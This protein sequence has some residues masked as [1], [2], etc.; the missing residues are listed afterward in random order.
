MAEMIPFK[1]SNEEPDQPDSSST[2]HAAQEPTP[3]RT[4]SAAEIRTYSNE[5][6]SEIIR[7]GLRSANGGQMD[8]VNHEEMLAIGR[9]FGLGPADIEHAFDAIQQTKTEGDQQTV[10]M[11]WFKVHAVTFVAIL[12]GLF[13]INLLD[14]PSFWWAFFPF[15]GWGSIVLLHGV[16]VRYFPSAFLLLVQDTDNPAMDSFG[17]S[18]SESP[19][20]TPVRF[21]IPELHHG[22]AEANGMVQ[23]KKDHLIIECQTRDTV[24]GAIKS[25]IKSLEVPYDEIQGV[26]LERQFSTIKLILQSHRLKTFEDIPGQE[27]GRITLLLDK[28]RRGASEKLARDLAERIG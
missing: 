17:Y 16:L 13:G 28:H 25:E 6:V 11:L 4:D 7:V 27:G 8:T 20:H 1:D 18:T 26:R 5:E 21:T 14:D 22:F 24:F 3:E 9:D 15:F 2:E 19:I 12:T 10:A 23:V